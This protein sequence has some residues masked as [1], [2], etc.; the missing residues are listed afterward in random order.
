MKIGQ[1]PMAKCLVF[2]GWLTNKLAIVVSKASYKSSKL[3]LS[4]MA[5]YVE[6]PH[7]DL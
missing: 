3:K 1:R 2:R 4:I 6:H 5:N 7:S